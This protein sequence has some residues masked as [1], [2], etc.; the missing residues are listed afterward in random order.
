MRL[1]RHFLF[2]LAGFLL[3]AISLLSFADVQ[4]A[5]YSANA[6][7]CTGPGTTVAV[8]TTASGCPNW[9][10]AILANS[11]SDACN[12]HYFLVSATT[13]SGGVCN[14]SYGGVQVGNT[15]SGSFSG[16]G[17]CASG[18][19]WNDSASGCVPV[20]PGG[21]TLDAQWNCVS[22]CTGGHVWDGSACS[23]P[24]ATVEEGGVCVTNCPGGY[25]RFTPDNGKC[26]KDCVGSQVQSPDGTCKCD[27]TGNKLY[28]I[29]ANAAGSVG[30]DNGCTTKA[31]LGTA[32]CPSV[33]WPIVSSGSVAPGT[34]CYVY[35]ARDGGLCNPNGTTEGRVNVTLKTQDSLPPP[36]QTGT[37]KDGSALDV[38]NTVANAKDPVACGDA[39]GNYVVVGGVSKC[40]STEGINSMDAVKKIDTKVSTT[41][42]RNADNTS[43]DTTE[44]TT[45][46]CDQGGQC[47]TVR[48]ISTVHKDAT[49]STTGGSSTSTTT[50]GKG[51]ADPSAGQCAKEPDSPLC[52][53]GKIADKGKF[54]SQQQD[55]D[56]TAAKEALTT[57][58]AQ[59]RSE[60][61]S[62]FSTFGAGPGSMPCPAP[63][64]VL[65]Q[66]FSLCFTAFES[67]LSVI[68]LAI[69]FCAAVA[70]VFL[71]LKR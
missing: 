70:T 32:Y 10:Q 35:G 69:Y 65:G 71:I 44:K 37:N 67:Q 51:S 52:R 43:S 7:R 16:A 63:I 57:G 34:N 58:I 29:T 15:V 12:N 3:S 66:P 39:G 13:G 40:L 61:S 18:R 55:A 36:D 59:V 38:K 54:D 2:F 24:P 50:D 64:T 20:C 33:N 56:L 4:L 21:Q 45:V 6:I 11:G 31:L 47:T 14:V 68:G 41:T 26:E 8:P 30:C 23:C 53:K 9:G 46:V 48:S 49:G 5:T 22:Q 1:F 27:P 42:T 62:L 28:Q 25:H 19:T 60:A 17:V